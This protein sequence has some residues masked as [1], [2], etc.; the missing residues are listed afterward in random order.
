M[1]LCVGLKSIGQQ[2]KISERLQH[3]SDGRTD[4]RTPGIS[5]SPAPLCVG[6]GQQRQKQT[7]KNKIN[8]NRVGKMGHWYGSIGQN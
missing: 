8:I 6:G 1:L 4:G 2:I 5:I 3:I 7:N